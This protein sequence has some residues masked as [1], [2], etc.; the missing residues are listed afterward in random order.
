M[1]FEGKSGKHHQNLSTQ[2]A[3]LYEQ[4]GPTSHLRDGVLP[5]V[6]SGTTPVFD[7]G[8]YIPQE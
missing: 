8:D 4:I 2:E 5:E 3:E 1:V 7:I 6:I